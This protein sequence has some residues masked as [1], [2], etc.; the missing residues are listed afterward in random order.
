[1]S[2]V[3][4]SKTELDRTIVI[5]QVVAKQLPQAKAALMLGLSTRQIKRLV[6]RFKR[7]GPH[8]LCHRG[9]GKPS[10]RQ[11]PKDLIEK[12]LAHLRTTYVGF[13]PTLA[14]EKLKEQERLVVSR[15]WLRQLMIQEGLWQAK[16]KKHNKIYY[17]RARRARYG[18]L[19]QVDGSHHAWFEDRGP[20]CVALVFVDDATSRLLQVYFC[21]TEN[22]QGYLE[23]LKRYVLHWGIPQELYTDKHAVFTVNHMRGGEQKGETHFAKTLKQ[24]NIKHHLANT[25]QAKGRVERMNR[26]LQDRLIKEFRLNNISS[27]SDANAFMPTFI[28]DY[29]RRFAKPAQS[30]ENKHLSLTDGQRL[31]LEDIFAIE[32]KRRV[33]KALTVQYENKVYAIGQVRAIRTLRKRGVMVRKYLNQNIKMFFDGQPLDIKLLEIDHN[34]KAPLSR[35]ELDIQLDY[36]HITQQ[37][38][39]D[40]NRGHSYFA[41]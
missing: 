41:E 12:V 32:E 20:K 13:G 2:R 7:E 18:E 37:M 34:Y 21:H 22:L 14:A 5:G 3:T 10:H 16:T 38:D 8:A 6:R 24:L 19:V 39:K 25:P 23:A 31:S 30:P 33:S 28:E 35:K 1:M 26:V 27:I 40:N 29:N 11:Y 15:E 9:R 36:N 17:P 4:M